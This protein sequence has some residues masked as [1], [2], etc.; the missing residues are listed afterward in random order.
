MQSRSTTWLATGLVALACACGGSGTSGTGGGDIGPGQDVQQGVL[1]IETAVSTHDVEVGAAVIVTCAVTR[2][3]Q[4][5]E[6]ATDFAVGGT[7]QFVKNGDQLSFDIAGQY[8]V[9]CAAAD[10]GLTDDTP[11]TINVGEARAV[12]ID[13]TVDPASVAAGT[14]ATVT[15]AATDAQGKPVSIQFMVDVSPS[16]GVTTTQ[17]GAPG[18]F[19][20]KSTKVGTYDVA[21]RN[22]DASL[23]DKTPASLEVTPGPLATV[24]TALDPATIA[25]GGDSQVAC[26]AF[27][28]YGNSLTIE[29]TI[30]APEGLTVTIA[31]TGGSVTGTK[32]GTYDITCGPKDGT[33]ADLKGA[34]LTIQAG[35]AVKLTLGLV[36]AKAAYAVTDTVQV[37]WTL[38]DAYDNP[39]AGGAVDPFTVDPAS[40]TTDKGGGSFT[41][42]A[43]G[44]YT[45]ATCVTGNSSVCAQIQAVCD[46]TAPTLVITFPER[47]ATLTG[48]RDI[49]VT[50]TVSDAVS[51]NQSLT[52]NGQAVT[53]NQDGTFGFPM[54]SDQAM[55]II[56]ATATDEWGNAKR[57]IQ[58]YL[59]SYTYYPMDAAN[60]AGSLVPYGLMTYLDDKLFYDADPADTG[61]ISVLLGMVLSTFDIMSMVPSP[62]TNVAAPS[63]LSCKWDVY[64]TSATYDPPTVTIQSADGGVQVDAA[65]PNLKMDILL[66][67]TDGG[68]LCPGDTVAHASA[69]AVNIGMAIGIAVDQASHALVLTAGASQISMENFSLSVDAWFNFLIGLFKDTIQNML[70]DQ[71]SSQIGGLVS[72]L[73]G[74]LSD[75]LSKPIDLQIAPLFPGMNAIDLAIMVQPQAAAFTKEGGELDLNMSITSPKLVERT[76]LGSIGRAACLLPG[77]VDGWTMTTTDPD[78]VQLAVFDDVANEALYAVWNNKG[79]HLH[80]TGDDLAQLGVDLSQYG[81]SG[82]DLTT[83]PLLPPVMTDCTG[84]GLNIQLG[85]FYAELILDLGGPVELHMYVFLKM[86]ADLMVV[87]DP[88]QGQMVGIQVHDPDYVEFDVVSID[89][90]HA[91]QEG[92]YAGI[93]K[94]LVPILFQKLTEKPIT[95]KIPAINLKSLA[96]GGTGGGLNLT[97]PD[98]DLILDVKQLG[99]DQGH[100]NLSA[101]IT[102]QDPPPA[103]P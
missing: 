13:T 79:L 37:T 34:K 88:A 26:A 71:F 32:A 51:T 9:A 39:V 64:L 11:E 91:G 81:M 8:T 77:A 54:T 6:A 12:A 31:G 10:L 15:C 76:I 98:K 62:L 60:P 83:A 102:I 29:F 52:I 43:E 47:G 99:H 69:D 36:P 38:V 56:D 27:D 96:G 41:F 85:D 24:T 25:A 73:N 90:A 23:K 63:P 19:S 93:L 101:G 57:I 75:L 61:T 40:G 50:G 48:N 44:I 65:I 42:D 66:K 103:T 72:S 68:F 14:S 67:K 49:T 7:V 53:I 100:T 78:K 4:A 97:L 5:I 86:R 46:G 74:T 95:F 33:K 16:E 92:Q 28:T 80:I 89:E 58:S 21:C 84:N 87:D 35:E 17:G 82:L 55:N 30:A 45:F 59:F 18:Q 20:L 70:Q 3:G 22:V 2:D 1:A 94:G